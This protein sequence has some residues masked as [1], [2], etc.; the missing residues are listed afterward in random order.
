MTQT[1]ILALPDFDKPF[2]IETDAS[3]VGLGA[4]LLQD[5]HPIAYFS[6]AFG[7]KHLLLATYEKELMAIVA[8]IQRWKG[9]LMNKPFIIKTDHQAL[10]YMLE[11]KECNPILQ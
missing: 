11:Q 4:V 7:S 9:Y 1:P 3:G 5:K 6:K 10:K 8:A 2:V